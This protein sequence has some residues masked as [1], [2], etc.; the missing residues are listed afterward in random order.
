M[1]PLVLNFLRKLIIFTALLS[2]VAVILEVIL[3]K[4]FISPTLPF[5]FLFFPAVT[6]L[7]YYIL[8]K[9]AHKKFIR[10]LNYFLV[11]TT[12]KLFLYIGVLIVYIL[13]NK[14]D[15]VPFVLSFFLMYL[16][17]TAFEVIQIVARSRMMEKK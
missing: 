13:L 2:V 16:G 7:S 15:A 8:L 4:S 12:V 6:L 3:P 1:K 5:L 17:Y 10:F 9:A 14:T 11:T